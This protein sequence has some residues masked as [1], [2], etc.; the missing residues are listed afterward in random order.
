MMPYERIRWAS[1]RLR[2]PVADSDAYTDSSIH[3]DL[4]ANADSISTMRAVRSSMSSPRMSPVVAI[5][6][7]LTIGL[8]GRPVPA[9]RLIALNGS[10]LGSAP[11]RSQDLVAARAR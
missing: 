7:A 11:T 10:P 4:P 1:A 8:A 3:S 6:P 2:S 9:S 5:A